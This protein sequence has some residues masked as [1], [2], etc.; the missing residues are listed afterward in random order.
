VTVRYELEKAVSP[1]YYKRNIEGLREAENS[2]RN[3]IKEHPNEELGYLQLN[4]IILSFKESRI[5]DG[6]SNLEIGLKEI[7][8][9]YKIKRELSF[10]YLKIKDI[11]KAYELMKNAIITFD[12]DELD[13]NDL[14]LLKS[15]IAISLNKNES[16]ISWGLLE[17]FDIPSK[18]DPRLVV[19]Y[20]QLL[21]SSGVPKKAIKK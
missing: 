21:V 16:T 3:F 19:L 10:L 13:E 20:S 6:I 5:Y 14:Q 4:D 8:D 1:K 12:G 18:K 15:F 2:T 17:K 9:S 11:E 7:S